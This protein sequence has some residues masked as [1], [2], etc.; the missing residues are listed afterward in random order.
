LL[1]ID[2]DHSYEGVVDDLTHWRRHLV[3]GAVVALHDVGVGFGVTRAVYHHLYRD[4]AF[5]RFE[6]HDSLLVC[7]YDPA[8][9]SRSR[10]ETS[11]TSFAMS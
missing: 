7:R 6:Q 9:A 10:V 11:S 3:D 5:G 8:A 4:P 1:F 2:A